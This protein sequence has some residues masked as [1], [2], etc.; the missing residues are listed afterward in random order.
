MPHRK[1]RVF[2]I[3]LLACDVEKAVEATSNPGL[4]YSAETGYGFLFKY[5]PIHI[6]SRGQATMPAQASPDMLA[7]YKKRR[8]VPPSH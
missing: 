1:I 7:G 4:G 8:S 3:M 5:R 6:L 2:T